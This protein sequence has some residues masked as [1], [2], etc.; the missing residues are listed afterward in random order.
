MPAPFSTRLNDEFSPVFYKD[1]VVYCS[2]QGNNNLLSYNP[3]EGKLFRIFIYTNDE[4]PKAWMPGLFA[5]E[6]NS[7]FNDGPVT[8]NE[9]ENIIYFSRNN[10]IDK[11]SISH[12]SS[13]NKLGIY[14]AELID[15][16]WGNFKAFPYNS[17]NWNCTTPALSSDGKRIYFSSDSPGGYGGMDLYCCEWNGNE[18]GLP[19][20]LGPTIN[21]PGNESFPFASKSEKLFFSSDGHPGFGGKDI[22]YARLEN[23]KW[24]DPVHLDSSINSPA[25]DFGIVT[26]SLFEKGY[27]STNRR[28]SG[29]IFEFRLK[30]VDFADCIDIGKNN[31]CYTFWDENQHIF[32]ND[33]IFY[34]WDFGEGIKINGEEAGHCF[35][36]PGH[37]IV[38]LTIRDRLTG[39]TITNQKEY[40][41]AI[42]NIEQAE[43]NSMFLCEANEPVKFKADIK[44]IPNFHAQNYYWDIG[45]GFK[46][47]GA[48]QILTLN[49][50]GNHIVKL[51]LIGKTDSLS[52]P[53]KYCYQKE[54]RVYNKGERLI[55]N[56]KKGVGDFIDKTSTISYPVSR[57]ISEIFTMKG[58]TSAQLSLIHE[59]LSDNELYELNF[60]RLGISSDSYDFLNS[61]S[62]IM[63]LDND[64]I[65]EVLFN[66]EIERFEKDYKIS[67]LFLRN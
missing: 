46:P 24:L 40:D 60:D 59:H 32:R 25:D 9:A 64:I 63:V 53:V 27:F 45:E 36:G 44:D 18:W 35:P 13:S 47:G 10:I 29:D 55:F 21:T 6:I 4:K 50:P 19:V 38:K 11:H 8:F 17:E 30:E 61:L 67:D 41:V 26:D 5:R 51:G 66:E 7:G 48:S 62:K 31:Y 2:N 39:D 20:N 22:F 12:A 3:K 43:I 58:L 1:G 37:Y 54:V 56:Y 49:E 42:D 28:N 15:G 33:S 16:V 14:S 52:D 65:V 57:I 23:G 34:E